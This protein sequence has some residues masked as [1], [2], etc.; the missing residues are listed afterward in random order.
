MKKSSGYQMSEINH[1]QSREKA[2][3]S[4][5][6]GMKKT[7]IGKYGVILVDECGKCSESAAKAH[8]EQQSPVL[9]K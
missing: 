5:K 4:V 7:S 1:C 8:G 2:Y 6:C 3:R 9:A